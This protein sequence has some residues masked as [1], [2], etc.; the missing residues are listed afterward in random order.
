MVQDLA[1]PESTRVGASKEYTSFLEGA[2]LRGPQSLHTAIHPEELADWEGKWQV[3]T[4]RV[5]PTSANK[6]L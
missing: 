2:T 4:K 6:A 5:H 1:L 3:L